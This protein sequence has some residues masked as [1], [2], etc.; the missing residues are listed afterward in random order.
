MP[1][2]MTPQELAIELSTDARTTRKFLRAITPRDAQPGKGSRWAVP[3]NAAALKVLNR[4]FAEWGAQQAELAA[5]RIAAKDEVAAQTA[6]EV[7]AELDAE[8][9]ADD[10]PA[11]LDELEGPSDADLAV[12][13]D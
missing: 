12:I 5:Q 4:R 8:T 3:A 10:A 2:T 7:I 1:K 13:E 9:P 6:D 11:A